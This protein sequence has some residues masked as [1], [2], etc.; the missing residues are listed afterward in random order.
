MPNL[1]R[2][3]P[4]LRVPIDPTP[5]IVTLHDG[6]RINV[7]LFIAR[8]HAIDELVEGTSPF[9]PLGI[10]DGV[11]LVARDAIASVTL[12]AIQ[13]TPREDLAEERQRVTIRMRHGEKVMG[14]LRWVAPPGHRRTLD[15]LNN[16]DTTHLVLWD[17]DFVTYLAKAHVVSVEETSC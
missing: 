7:R 9:V 1:E 4:I 5:A 12:H 10:V 15:H 8:G 14:E 16:S 3:Q 11:R 6:S 17:G 2:S 13:V